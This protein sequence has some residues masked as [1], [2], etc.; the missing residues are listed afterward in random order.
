[1]TYGN[2]P[3]FDRVKK[4]LIIKMRHLG[5]VLLSTPVLSVLKKRFPEICIDALVYDESKAVLEDHFAIHRVYSHKRL[6]KKLFFIKRLVKEYSLLREL[7]KNKYDLILNLTEGDRG[8]IVSK[9]CKPLYRVGVESKN[10]FYTHTIKQCTTLR[11]QVERDLDALRVMGI[12]PKV[13]ERELSFFIP[14]TSY[15]KTEG[16]E[17]F[18]LFCPFSRWKFKSLSMEKMRAIVSYLTEKKQKIILAGSKDPIEMQKAQDLIE[19]FDVK[20]VTNLV[21]KISIKELGA[22]MDKSKAVICVDS[23]ALHMSSCLK[24]KTLCFFGPTSEVKWGPWQN[25]EAVIITK[26]LSCRPCLL[27][28]CGGSKYSDCLEQIDLSQAFSYLDQWIK[29]PKSSL[30]NV[31]NSK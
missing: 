31:F 4:I 1:M 12:F 24:K 25:P 30:L 8:A 21:G 22:F 7:K 10:K 16:Y 11:H 23:L 17:D 14:K 26:N 13:E 15:K 18:F 19:G 3:D 27:D 2:Y 29:K 9:Y 5:D 6:D 28:G 20:L